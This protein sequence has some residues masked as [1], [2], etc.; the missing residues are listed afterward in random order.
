MAAQPS[1]LDQYSQCVTD[2]DSSSQQSSENESEEEEDSEDDEFMQQL[3]R[4]ALLSE[5][6]ESRGVRAP[7]PLITLSE[8]KGRGVRLIY[9]GMKV[10]SMSEFFLIVA[11][12]TEHQKR[13]FTMRGKPGFCTASCPC[14]GCNFHINASF[15]PEERMWVV[16]KIHFV[17]EHTCQPKSG[18]SCHIIYKK[19]RWM[20]FHPITLTS[21]L[22]YDFLFS[23]ECTYLT[24]TKQQNLSQAADFPV[25]RTRTF[26]SCRLSPHCCCVCQMLVIHR[27]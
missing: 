9:E 16:G 25:Q 11:E 23:S 8:L 26:S 2:E 7:R 18:M 10:S 4:E 17:D 1:F 22:E 27:W 14:E 24:H 5:R 3:R 12:E 20:C 19:L 21:I 15:I 13:R 6:E